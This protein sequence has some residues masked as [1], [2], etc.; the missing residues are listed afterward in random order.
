MTN[1]AGDRATDS[2]VMQGPAWFSDHVPRASLVSHTE[3]RSAIFTPY[4]K[5]GHP[6]LA[7]E[8]TGKDGQWRRA[9]LTRAK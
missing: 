8:A 4:E 5:D 1:H 3:R 9:E 7:G 2:F 6:V